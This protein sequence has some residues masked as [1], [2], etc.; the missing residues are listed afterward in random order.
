M[1]IRGL[2]SASRPALA[3]LLESVQSFDAAEV[4]VALELADAALA[5]PQQPD[6]RF[7]LAW[8]GDALA[9]YICFGPTPMTDGTFDLY[10]LAT[11]PA[12]TR[13]GVAR[14]LVEAME[15]QLRVD[16]ARMVRVE[17]SSRDGYGA[18]AAFYVAAGYEEAARLRDFY[19]EGDDLIT[20]TRRFTER[21]L[22]D[23]VEAYRLA[24][25]YRDF[26]AERDFLV[27][28]SA[29]FGLGDPGRVVEWA[30]GPAQHLEHFGRDRERALV[31]VDR[32]EE[33]LQAAR[34]R[35]GD[36]AELVLA[37]MCEWVVRP[38]AE[39]GFIPL[40]SV[41]MLARADRI[42]AF[43]DAARRSLVPGG[44]MVIEATHPR[45][46]TPEGAWATDWRIHERGIELEARTRFDLARRNGP[47]VPLTLS[48]R[49]R[50]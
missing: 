11:S 50:R 31:G 2:D 35:L 46:L 1:R 38:G 23:E 6:Y 32:S 39:L 42:A 16:G 43:L 5:D 20:F 41:H 17:T 34:R 18:A 7:L 40:S 37:D 10:W 33:M 4:L 29:R 13:R 49:S 36:R 8:E 12:F 19:S 48:I 25:E 14:R 26:A 15:A 21:A 45:D 24:F 30:C 44:V 28:C 3:A 27:A 22:G 9:G 47:Q